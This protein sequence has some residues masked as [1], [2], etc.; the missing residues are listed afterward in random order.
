MWTEITWSRPILIA[1]ALCLLGATPTAR[2]VCEARSSSAELQ[3]PRPRS[4]FDP[5][6]INW[7]GRAELTGC[8]RVYGGGRDPCPLASRTPHPILLSLYVTDRYVS[9][10][11]SLFGT[12]ATGSVSG[13][14]SAQTLQ[15]TAVLE[16]SEDDGVVAIANW[17]LAEVETG[18]APSELQ[19]RRD[20]RNLS[21]RQVTFETYGVSSL[22][23]VE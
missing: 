8:R 10:R 9:G 2:G 18:L 4:A 3:S 23:R 19:V 7:T 6:S 11:L 1:A 22:S 17:Q 5:A 14:E 12:P 16:R 20:W 13:T 21:G 15:L